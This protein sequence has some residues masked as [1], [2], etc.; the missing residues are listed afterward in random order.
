M[1]NEENQPTNKCNQTAGNCGEHEPTHHTELV[2]KLAIIVP[3]YDARMD[4][5][6]IH[7]APVRIGDPGAQYY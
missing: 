6:F 5:A 7:F 4:G 1:E 2:K 3:V